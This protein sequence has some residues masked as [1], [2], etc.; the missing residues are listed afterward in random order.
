M[1]KWLLINLPH[2][3]FLM[4]YGILY[5]S[6]A[7]K[8]MKDSAEVL[9]QNLTYLKEARSDFWIRMI[10]QENVDVIAMGGYSWQCSI[11]REICAE[12]RKIPE[13]KTIIV[14]GGGIITTNPLVA[15]EALEEADIGIIG[16]GEEAICELADKIN[17]GGDISAIPGLVFKREGEWVLTQKRKYQWNLDARPFP[18][19]EGFDYSVFIQQS[20]AEPYFGIFASRSCA[21]HCTFCFHYEPYRQRSLDSVFAELDVIMKEY[22]NPSFIHFYDELFSVNKE[23]VKEFCQRIKKYQ[24]TYEIYLRVTD[25][26]VELVSLLK[27]SGCVTIGIGLE[28]YSDNI[29]RSM[30]KKITSQDIDRA[31]KILEE[32]QVGVMGNFILGDPRDTEET[33]QE[34]LRF[35]D[36][37]PEYNIN[38]YMIRT[39][40]GSDIY[41]YALSHGFIK[42]EIDFLRKDCPYINIS[43]LTDE[44]WK[45]LS[46][47][48]VQETIYSERYLTDFELKPLSFHANNGYGEG[49]YT[50]ICPKCRMR[51]I[52]RSTLMRFIP[53]HV[54]E[55]CH[56]R[57]SI[58]PLRYFEAESYQFDRKLH[59]V[60]WGCNELVH[61]LLKEYDFLKDYVELVDKN[62]DIV[63]RRIF[64]K[65]I[66]ETSMAFSADVC[67]I[68]ALAAKAEIT[69]AI[70]SGQS[71]V[72]TILYPA[73]MKKQGKIKLYLHEMTTSEKSILK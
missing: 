4:P 61:Y 27:E 71:R 43:Q 12:I 51:T 49:I 21:F 34:S 55:G 66:K 18:D 25:I 64:G 30:N 35:R 38:I 65:E 10:K 44:R 47:L 17:T 45:E 16:E 23:R 72:K 1:K 11:M 50:M 29:L 73:L 19:R 54:C 7:L 62:S 67:I 59:Y 36:E 69:K 8:I 5:I 2:D 24:I 48:C 57:F 33:V 31:L 14:V 40:P 26:T 32:C 6:S 68:T 63:G 42:D 13:H 22:N 53:K 28:S 15:M 39:L 52:L 20:Y 37:H 58:D 3:S 60:I 70:C 46:D 41:Q 56:S 9:T